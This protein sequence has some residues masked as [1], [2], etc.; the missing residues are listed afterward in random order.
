[1]S[2]EV[3]PRKPG[4]QVMRAL[5]ALPL[6][7]CIFLTACSIPMKVPLRVKP[8]MG[9][10][11]MAEPNV[12]VIRPGVTT[13]AEILHQFA[14]FDAGWKGERLFLGRWLRS[15]FS[16]EGISWRRWGGENLVVEFDEKG[17]VVRYQVLSDK[18]FLENED[19]VLLTSDERLSGFRESASSEKCLKATWIGSR[20]PACGAT[21]A[22][23]NIMGRDLLEISGAYPGNNQ[24]VRGRY[25][26]AAEQI[27]E[28]LPYGYTTDHDNGIE[29]QP[30][31]SDF[32]LSIRLKEPIRTVSATGTHEEN[33]DTKVLKLDTDVPTVVQLVRFVYMS[34]TK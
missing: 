31:T 4:A 16:Q 25:R 3:S 12:R 9:G 10:D 5:V 20:Q 27:E 32:V 26:I 8:V 19:S 11:L 15:G 17:T 13:R 2:E 21:I 18:D 22:I 29:I 28:F 14:V 33:S 1:M 34:R 6:H 30:V 23:V 24:F 7:F